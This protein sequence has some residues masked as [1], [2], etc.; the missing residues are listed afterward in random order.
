MRDLI[1]DTESGAY[2]SGC[3]QQVVGQKWPGKLTREQ[4]LKILL[5]V[6][7]KDD[8]AWEFATDDFYD[9]ETDTMPSIWHVMEAL[10]FSVD[11]VNRANGLAQ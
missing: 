2:P 1:E 11:E 10:G 7:E 9:E 3:E 5:N 4:A 8:P 6:T